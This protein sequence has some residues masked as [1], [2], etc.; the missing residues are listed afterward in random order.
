MSRT[1]HETIRLRWQ[2]LGPEAVIEPG[3]YHDAGKWAAGECQEPETD[4]GCS[5]CQEE[6]EEVADEIEKHYKVMNREVVDFMLVNR[7]PDDGYWEY[8]V[9]SRKT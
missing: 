5:A 3:I 1:K 6:M 7:P 9:E 2:G 8:E 4:D